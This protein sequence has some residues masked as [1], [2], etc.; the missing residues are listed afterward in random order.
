[1]AGKVKGAMCELVLSG[2]TRSWKTYAFLRR[3]AVIFIL[4]LS[5]KVWDG[6]SQFSVDKA[7]LVMTQPAGTVKLHLRVSDPKDPSGIPKVTQEDHERRRLLSSKKQV[8]L[9]VLKVTVLMFSEDQTWD[10]STSRA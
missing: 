3:K 2:V 10:P 4:G 6:V 5:D 1:M 9:E 7:K 8:V